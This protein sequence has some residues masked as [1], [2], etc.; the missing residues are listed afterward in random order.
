MQRSHEI[1]CKWLRL[2]LHVY[3]LRKPLARLGQIYMV[4]IYWSENLPTAGPRSSDT[5][6]L[7]PHQATWRTTMPTRILLKKKSKIIFV[8][9]GNTVP[10]FSYTTTELT[11]CIEAD[12]IVVLR[13]I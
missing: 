13:L 4:R 12:K 5:E 1:L 9:L 3:I 10:E 8:I 11:I 2:H 6:A 7:L